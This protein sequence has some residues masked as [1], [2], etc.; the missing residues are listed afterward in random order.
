MSKKPFEV[1]DVEAWRKASD[2]CPGKVPHPTEPKCKHR[3][4]L[5]VNGRLQQDGCQFD[6]CTFWYF[7]RHVGG[8]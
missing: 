8:I 7:S 4:F 1:L 5:G 3:T 6:K 2:G